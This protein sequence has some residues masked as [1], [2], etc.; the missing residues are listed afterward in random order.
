MIDIAA[1]D[2]HDNK[3]FATA[4]ARAALMGA[5]LHRIEDDRGRDVFIVTKWALTREL[6]DLDAVETWLDRVEGRT[7]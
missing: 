4:R 7:G 3:R 1:T 2:P 6:R 5:T